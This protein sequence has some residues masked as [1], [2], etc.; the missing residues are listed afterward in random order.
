[1]SKIG[2]SGSVA[3][4]FQSTQITPLLAL[5][6][7]LLGVFAVLVT[8]REEEPKINVTFANVFNPF[9]GPSEREVA[10]LVAS[11]AEKVLD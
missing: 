6:G 3:Q 9:P 7:I 5:V 11:P 10:S 4:R 8:P 1:M 2:L